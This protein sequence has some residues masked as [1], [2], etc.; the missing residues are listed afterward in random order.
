MKLTESEQS[1]SLWYKCEVVRRRMAQ[2]RSESLGTRLRL[3]DIF[4]NMWRINEF[5]T[6]L[7]LPPLSSVAVFVVFLS[8][9]L[10]SVGLVSMT[11]WVILEL[12]IQGIN[13]LML[14]L[15]IYTLGMCP[16][17]WMFYRLFYS[18]QTNWWNRHILIQLGFSLF[19]LFLTHLSK[20]GKSIPF[21]CSKLIISFQVIFPKLTEPNQRHRNLLYFMAW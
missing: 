15:I 4:L 8:T 21:I 12:A 16:N 3:V 19:C 9:Y 11:S 20:S 7:K 6:V 13:N 18:R 5:T 2:P 14:V 1:N 10:D 17:F